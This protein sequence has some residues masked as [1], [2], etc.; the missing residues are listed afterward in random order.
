[1]TVELRSK[2]TIGTP[3]TISTAPLCRCGAHTVTAPTTYSSGQF[4]LQVDNLV[5]DY[6]HV[7]ERKTHLPVYREDIDNAEACQGAPS[8]KIP[9]RRSPSTHV[10]CECHVFKPHKSLGKQL[11]QS[12]LS[13]G[14]TEHHYRYSST[15]RLRYR[16]LP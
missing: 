9:G 4:C 3:G 16:Y 8:R 7:D 13:T 12:M 10:L 14:C 15:R 1:M 2:A 11:M 6:F 5:V